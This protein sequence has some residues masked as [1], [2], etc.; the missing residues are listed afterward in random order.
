MP[1][2]ILLAFASTAVLLSAAAYGHAKLQSSSPADHAQLTVAPITL[3]LTFNESAKLAKLTLKGSTKEI[4]VTLDHDAKSATT[5][6]VTLPTLS[7]DTYEVQW[8]AM[9]VEDGHIT[10]GTLTFTV[11]K[12][13]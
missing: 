8:T 13:P 7:P 4:P 2:N 10:K 6:T 12:S 11:S 9:A 5:V 3:S 1:R